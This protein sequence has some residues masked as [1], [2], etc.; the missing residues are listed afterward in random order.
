[1]GIGAWI[2]WCGVRGV[3]LNHEKLFRI[4]REERLTV[5]SRGGRKW[6][7]GTRALTALPQGPDQRRSLNFV[8]DMMGV[9]VVVDDFIREYLSLVVDTSISDRR[10]ARELDAIV[11]A[12][13]R[14]PMII[15]DNAT[16]LTLHAIMRW[17]EERGI[18]W[19]YI[20]PGKP[21]Q[22]AFVE[23]LNGGSRDES[24]NELPMARRIIEAR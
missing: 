8:S 9:L 10:M 18:G 20:A 11:A 7:L 2:F 6:A 24:L 3:A 13:K 22:K 14:L 15:S 16:E 19:H 21:V 17:Q 5:R 4:Y 23:S 12:R 1:L